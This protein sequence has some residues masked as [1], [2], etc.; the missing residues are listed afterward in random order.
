MATTTVLTSDT[1]TLKATFTDTNNSALDPD[2]SVATFTVYLND[3]L[4]V[5]TTGTA[6]K[7]AT[8]IYSYDWLV[9]KDD[10]VGYILEMKGLFS[11]EPQLQRMRI[12]SKFRP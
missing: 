7:I 1:I 4:S 2:G 11:T 8:G 6:T 9:P 3:D 12:K 5:V 10:G